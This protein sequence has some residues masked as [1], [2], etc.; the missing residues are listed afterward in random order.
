MKKKNTHR[1]ALEREEKK[2]YNR[3][4]IDTILMEAETG[5][6]PFFVIFSHVEY[7][8]VKSIF[9]FYEKKKNDK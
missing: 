4:M 8:K 9:F 6:V 5:W 3:T 7:G 1:L 2:K